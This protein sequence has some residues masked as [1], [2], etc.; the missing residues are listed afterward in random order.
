[1]T[2]EMVTIKELVL[3]AGRGESKAAGVV[4]DYLRF[5]RH[6]RYYD[7]FDFVQSVLPQMDLARWDTLLYAAGEPGQPRLPGLRGGP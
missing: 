3:R 6:M 1:M 2:A 4:H 5:T 7:I